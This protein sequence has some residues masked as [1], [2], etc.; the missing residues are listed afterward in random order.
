MGRRKRSHHRFP[1][2]LPLA[3][4]MVLILPKPPT[5]EH[6]DGSS[7]EKDI[8]RALV[9]CLIQ[10]SRL[11][12]TLSSPGSS[13]T[14]WRLGDWG[15]IFSPTQMMEFKSEMFGDFVNKLWSQLE[16]TLIGLVTVQSLLLRK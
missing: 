7:M 14:S 4:I 5:L 6:P 11:T 9:Q 16:L 15:K 2:C 12:W 8:V 1:S 10:L 13:L 3:S